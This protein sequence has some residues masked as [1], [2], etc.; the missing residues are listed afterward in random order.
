M[1]DCQFALQREVVMAAM[2]AKPGAVGCGD[3]TGLGMDSNETLTT[4]YGERWEGVNFAG[5]RKGELGS[6][7]ATAFRDQAQTLPPLDGAQVHRHRPVRRA[8]AGERQRQE[9]GRQGPAQAG[10]R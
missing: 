4:K 8:E 2:D 3:S 1:Q 10:G 9:R 5:T 6:G 7:L